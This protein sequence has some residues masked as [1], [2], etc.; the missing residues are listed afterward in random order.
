MMNVSSV[1]I[2]KVREEQ[3]SK[4]R[5]QGEFVFPVCPQRL[6]E[7]DIILLSELYSTRKRDDKPIRFSMTFSSFEKIRNMRTAFA[8]RAILIRGKN[9]RRLRTPFD[10]G[11]VKVSNKNYSRCP[12]V[13]YID[14][15]DL[16]E[17]LTRDL[18]D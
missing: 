13:A 18:L 1:A 11:E 3:L 10:I 8:Q 16:S 17:L 4:A 2:L 7:N 15:R 12:R 14:D 5:A 6:N 9:F